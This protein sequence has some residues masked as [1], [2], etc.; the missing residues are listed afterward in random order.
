MLILLLSYLGG[1][2]TILSPC[3][4]PVLPF[5]FAKSDQ[6][7][8][9]SGLPILLGMVLT[10]SVVACASAAGGSWIS[11]ANEYGRAL[12]LFVFFLLGL[13]LLVPELADKLASP[14]IQ[15]GNKLQKKAD[16]QRGFGGGLL[17]GISVGFLWA[18]CTGPILGLVL[19][20]AS[21]EKSYSSTFGLLLAFATGAASSLAV[22][23]FASAQ[24][25][26]KIKTGLGAEVWI[27][28]ALGVLVISTVVLIS[29]RLDTKIL[30]RFSYVNTSWLEQQ[31]VEKLSGHSIQKSAAKTESTED[32][33]LAADFSGAI[34]WINSAPLNLESLQGKVILVDF[35][36]YS[37]INCLRTLP[38]LKSWY[39]KYKDQGLVIIGVHSPEFAF[40]RDPENV[41]RAVKELSIP[42]AVAVDSEMA[43]WSRYKNKYWPAH[44]FIDR[45]GHIRHHHFGE[46][47]YEESEKVIQSLL[48]SSSSE[49]ATPI[50]SDGVQAPSSGIESRSPETYLGYKRL[51]GYEGSP[52]IRSN[53]AVRYQENR[54]LSPDHWS[55][56][57]KWKISEDSAQTATAKTAL[58]YRFRARDLHLVLGPGDHSGSKNV[59]FRVTLDG[60]P[61]GSSHGLDINEDGYGTIQTHRLYQLIRQK[62]GNAE[63]IFKIEFLDPGAEAFAFTFG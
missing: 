53:E 60:K 49:V 2:L 41:R 46:G 18:P 7:F 50:I 19:A 4:L 52:E 47:N 59:R 12:G 1:M 51:D 44:Y 25:I 63:H 62:D 61:P 55:L 37:C 36:T 27:K 5:L 20:G 8:R 24:V 21:L 38:Y 43:I 14:F 11:K 57:G 34:E 30:A 39:E 48:Q 22:G 32:E 23:I 45:S 26:K 17:L 10:F 42:Y 40:E 15:L 6:P 35:W 58:S 31:L 3:V 9:K 33:G 54:N 16:S 13:T 56:S 28:K 29:L